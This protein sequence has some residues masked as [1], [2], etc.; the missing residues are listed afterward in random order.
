VSSYDSYIYSLD[1]LTG[2]VLWKSM[3]ENKVKTSPVVWKEYLFVAADEMLYCFTSRNVE[4]K[5]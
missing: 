1:A 5:F 3:L 2:K 4:K